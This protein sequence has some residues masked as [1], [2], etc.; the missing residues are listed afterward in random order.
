[1]LQV[2]SGAV[3]DPGRHHRHG[4]AGRPRAGVQGLPDRR[5]VEPDTPVVM[6]MTPDR[7]AAVA[8]TLALSACRAAPPS[9]PKDATAGHEHTAPHHG[10]LVELGEEFAHVELVLDRKAGRLTAYVLDG[11]A[12][13]PVR[14]TQPTLT[15]MCTAPPALA[16]Q[17]L[18]L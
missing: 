10:Q 7:V 11:E 3:A 16:K 17:P 8:L 9:P 5:R 13:Q 18:E 2:R 4:R 1:C 15:L 12:E 6:G 14:V